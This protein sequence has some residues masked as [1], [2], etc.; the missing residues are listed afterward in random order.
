MDRTLIV[1]GGGPAGVLTAVLLARRGYDMSLLTADRPRPRVEGL[2]QRVVDVL[3]AQ[4][5]QHAL[6]AVGPQVGRVALWSGERGPRNVEFA[7]ERAAFD[8]ALLRDAAANGVRC[9][10]VRKVQLAKAARPRRINLETTDGQS[11]ALSARMIIEARGRSAPLPSVRAISGPSTTALISEV[12][13]GPAGAGTCVESFPDGWAWYVADGA[14]AFLQIFVDSAGGLPKRAELRGFFDACAGSLTLAP[15]LMGTGQPA[16]PLATRTATPRLARTLLTETV[17]RVGDA[18]SAVD[19]LSGHGVFEALG[20]ALAASA[21]VHTIL[22]TPESTPLAH[23]FYEERTRFAFD[24]FAR[25]GRDFY[26]LETR[27]ADRPFW[28]ARADWPDD[29]PAHAPALG[30]PARIERRPVVADGLVVERRVVVT[31]DQPRGIWQIDGVPLAELIDG[32]REKENAALAECSSGLGARLGVTEAKLATALDWLRS[33]KILTMADTIA[34][35]RAAI[36]LPGDAREV[37]AAD[38]SP[39]E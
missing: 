16:G 4:G 18:A 13:G 35:D 14:R 7:T 39:R 26:R 27:W 12:T 30:A 9:R 34:L 24:R 15:E 31:P 29:A 3:A 11:E 10:T 5:L 36:T 25:V 23:R 6:D 21:A 38:R 1:L 22:K 17:I 32:L 33:R 28:R 20:S 2:S 37:D 19:P 8:A